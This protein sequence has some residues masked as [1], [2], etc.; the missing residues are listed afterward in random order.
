MRDLFNGILLRQHKTG[1]LVRTTLP[2][3]NPLNRNR[4]MINKKRIITLINYIESIKPSSWYYN[5]F[6]DVVECLKYLLNEDFR[7]YTYQYCYHKYRFADI[8]ITKLTEE[9]WV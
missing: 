5:Q 3:S 4:N 9:I 8:V 7:K 6:P 2:Y 1:G